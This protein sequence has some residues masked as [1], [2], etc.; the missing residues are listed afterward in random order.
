MERPKIITINRNTYLGFMDGNK[1]TKA[2]EYREGYSGRECWL[3][4][5]VVDDLGEMEVGAGSEV[6]IKEMTDEMAEDFDISFAR[7][8]KA[9]GLQEKY[10]LLSA[11]KHIKARGNALGR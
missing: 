4:Y 8:E 11:L 6:S 10:S 9:K 5:Y 2:C 7:I 3:S 1:L